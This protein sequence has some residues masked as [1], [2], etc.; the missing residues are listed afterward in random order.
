MKYTRICIFKKSS[1]YF[2]FLVTFNN[3]MH[4]RNYINMMCDKRHFD[5]IG[6]HMVDSNGEPTDDE[7]FKFN[8]Y[9]DTKVNK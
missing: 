4:E 5:L 8:V 9:T 1:K 2:T 7:S 3:E 6:M